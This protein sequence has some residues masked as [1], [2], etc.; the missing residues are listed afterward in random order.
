MKKPITFLIARSLLIVLLIISPRVV[1]TSFAT[2]Y[3]MNSDSAMIKDG[4]ADKAAITLIRIDLV[5]EDLV[6]P[7]KESA[8]SYQRKVERMNEVFRVRIT[9]PDGTPIMQGTY[10]DAELTIPHG[11]HIH[12]YWT[13]QLESKGMY[14]NGVKTGVWERYSFNGERLSE[15]VYD[16]I[17]IADMN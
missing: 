15:K 7:P 1:S 8:V 11:L 10:L 2:A 14:N 9:A 4:A 17:E 12:F 6:S 13:G 3:S 5:G 16:L